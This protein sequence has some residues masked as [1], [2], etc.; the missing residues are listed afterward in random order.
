MN[1]ILLATVLFLS[2]NLY[3]SPKNTYRALNL[4]KNNWKMAIHQ[5]K[6][7]INLL[8]SIALN[9]KLNMQTRWRSVIAAMSSTNVSKRKVLIKNILQSK[10]WFLRNALL[11]GAQS[12]PRN[13][14]LAIGK[15]LLGDKSL[16]VR[17]EAVKLIKHHRGV[18]LKKDLQLSLKSSINYKNGK[19]LW[20]KRHIQEALA[21]F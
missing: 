10:E 18:E 17:T 19:P 5:M 21:S 11:V 3:A 8:S 6:P 2:F 16:L 20:I 4:P 9:K 13:N 15:I 12:L 7:D 1:K 14:A